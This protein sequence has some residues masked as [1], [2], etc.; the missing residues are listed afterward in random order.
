MLL[1]PSGRALGMDAMLGLK[2]TALRTIQC[3]TGTFKTLKQHIA[4]AMLRTE[5]AI[6]MDM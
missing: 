2:H 1:D 4:P 3:R 5:G 6:F